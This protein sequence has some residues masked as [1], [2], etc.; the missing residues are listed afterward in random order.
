MLRLLADPDNF[1]FSLLPY[2][3]TPILPYSHT[4]LLPY[5]L[6][7]RGEGRDARAERL[8]LQTAT[9]RAALASQPVIGLV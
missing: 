1:S 7:T 8:A 9:G 4:A 6:P 2:C 3:P 5:C